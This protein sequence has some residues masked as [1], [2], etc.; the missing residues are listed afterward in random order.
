MD[1]LNAFLNG[2]WY[3]LHD[4]PDHLVTHPA[5]KAR[6]TADDEAMREHRRGQM[7]DVVGDDEIPAS[8]SSQRLGRPI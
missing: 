6:F 1:Y 2:H 7:F 4:V 8:Q 5:T 3:L